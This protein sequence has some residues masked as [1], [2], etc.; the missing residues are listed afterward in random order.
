MAIDAEMQSRSI[1]LSNWPRMERILH[2]LPV[3][4]PV[5]NFH[6]IKLAA[7]GVVEYMVSTGMSDHPRYDRSLNLHFLWLTGS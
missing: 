2:S 3:F 1:L 4:R 6:T 5:I 7:Y